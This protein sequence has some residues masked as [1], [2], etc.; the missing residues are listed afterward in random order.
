M[1]ITEA[2]NAFSDAA[3]VSIGMSEMFT[4]TAASSNPA[5]LVLTTLDR[6]EYT[7]GESGV[8][9]TIS[10][11]G[12]TLNLIGI[13]G[14]ARSNGIVFTYQASSGRYLNGTYGYFDQLSYNA[15]GSAGELADISLFGTGSLSLANAYAAN[16]YDL[17]Q[18]D[19]AGYLGTATVVTQPDFTGA[20]PAQATPNSI[21]AI[22]ENFVG[23]DWNENGC[24]VLCST[25]AADA[26]AALPMQSTL[27]GLAGR[28]NGEWTLAYDGPAGQSGNWQSMLKPGE[29]VVIGT[30]GG[31]GHITTVV[32]G[33]GST[34]MLVDNAIFETA[35]GTVTNPANDGSGSDIVIQPQ[36]LASAEWTGVQA[37]SVVIYELDT[38]VVTDTVASDSLGIGASQSL[39]SLFTATDPANKPIADWQVYNSLNTDALVLGGTDD[40]GR[41]SAASAISTTSLTGL[42][43]LAGAT[44]GTDTLEARAFNGSYWGDWQS[45]AVTIAATTTPAAAPPVL[46]AQ[47]PKQIWPEGQP[48]SF[49]LPANTFADPQGENLAYTA[50]QY[51]G[52]ALPTWVTF[53]AL[54]NT[55][56]GIAP[57]NNHNLGIKGTA[58]DTSGLSAAEVFNADVVPA[59]PVIRPEISVTPTAKQIWTDGQTVDFKLPADTF[60]DAL[61]LPLRFTAFQVGGPEVT[62][63]L[64]FDPATDELFGR[65]PAF[66]HGT[67]QLAVIATD[68]L[69]LTAED[70]FGVTLAP[71]PGHAPFSDT[72]GPPAMAVLLAPPEPA[73]ALPFHA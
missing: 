26:G 3:A 56:S 62:R 17:M 21:A 25:I 63:W 59:P 28:P 40:F 38:P 73:N 35:G 39:A 61:G 67:V 9:G 11:N 68:A 10:G 72:A 45:L 31:G 66:A 51:N 48:F 42:S 13:D 47:T 43:L 7:A 58:T 1:P 65:V 22:A 30:P 15:S 55:F 27:I 16:A 53:N 54:T 70:V 44:A 37:D 36:H 18:V 19:A 20:V 23:Q 4:V 24:W 8:T 46:Q 64:Y 57:A 5:Y 12:H 52:A 41:N 69:H 2:R 32:S 29:M 50:T 49:T 34:A 6:N 14:D 60:T 33:A 71:R